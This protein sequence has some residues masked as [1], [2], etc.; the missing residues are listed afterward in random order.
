MGGIF[1]IFFIFHFSF[2]IFF[3]GGRPRLLTVRRGVRLQHILWGDP[4]SEEMACI[5]INGFGRMGKIFLRV[6]LKY[7]PELEVAAVNSLADAKTTA[8]IFKYDSVHG[9]FDGE[10][11]VRSDNEIE[12]DGASIYVLSEREPERLP[13]SEIG[14]DIVVEATGAFR[15]GEEAARHLKAGC[16]KVIITA[17]AKRV[18]ATIVPGVNENIYDAE[19]H[20][21]ISLASCTTNC[22]APVVKVLNENFIINRGFMTTV[23]AYT[24]DQNILDKKHRDLRRARAAALSIIP[25]T[26][27]AAV[28]IGEVMPDLAGKMDGIALRVPTADVSIVDL[29][30]EVEREVHDAEQVNDVF[31][32]AAS[33]TLKGILAVEREPLVSA[34]FVGSTYSAIVDAPLTNVIS[35][36]ASSTDNGEGSLIKVLAWYDNE[37]GYC[38]RVLD[39]VKII[40]GKL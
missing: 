3:T 18:D 13:W 38:C 32:H 9:R 31:E 34:D 10:V 37:W 24:N 27:G 21:I 28:S 22:L 6:L 25:T 15:S 33:N 11:R 36:S 30:V 14:V 5:G 12:I 8:H 17:P 4:I 2:F 35:N 19:K 39:M 16:R 1:F 29:V 23:H 40:S 26:T 7:A 20:N